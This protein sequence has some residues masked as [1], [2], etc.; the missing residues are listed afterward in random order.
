MA[1]A[2]G[3][4]ELC[5]T[6]LARLELQCWGSLWIPEHR[7]PSPSMGDLGKAWD[8]LCHAKVSSWQGND[9]TALRVDVS[10]PIP[11]VGSG[12]LLYL[13]CR[14]RWIVPQEGLCLC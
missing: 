13:S 14:V 1:S 8:S 10:C 12:P 7:H 6:S 2:S 3:V 11:A 9:S 5:K 4:G